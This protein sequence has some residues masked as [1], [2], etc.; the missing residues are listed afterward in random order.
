[1]V[2]TSY[3]LMGKLYLRQKMFSD[4]F[5]CLKKATEYNLNYKRVQ[6]Y[7]DFTEGVIHLIKRKIKKGIQILSDL[8][9]IL[10]NTEK[11]HNQALI[12]RVFGYVAIE[13]Y[14]Q[15]LVDIKKVKKH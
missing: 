7:L 11:L 8:I 2:G 12:Y 3:F 9:E 4:A 1:M 13:K 10:Q 5:E 6:L 15:A 14:E